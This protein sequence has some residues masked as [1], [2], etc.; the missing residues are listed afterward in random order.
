MVSAALTALALVLCVEGPALELPWACATDERCTQ[1]HNGGSHTGT[2]AWA[3]DFALQHGEEIWAASAGTVTHLRKNSTVSG[4]NSAY[5]ADANFVTI[6]HGD[7]TAII[8]AHMQ[9]G[10]IPLEVGDVVEVGDLIGKVGD[11][12]Y[13]CGSHLH[14]AVQDQ[15]GSSHCQSVPAA[16]AEIGDAADSTT[17][18]S[19]NCPVC[20]HALDGGITTLDDRDAGC[21]TRITTSWWSSMEGH[22]AHHFYTFATDEDAPVSSAIWHVRVQTPGD[23][24][25][26]AF[27][28]EQDAD[29]ENAIY[30]VHHDGGT[31]EVAVDQ[32]QAKGWQALGTFAFSAAEGLAIEL[33]DATGENIDTLTRR[34]GYDA[35]RF[36]FVPSA[37][38]DETGASTGGSDVG[39]TDGGGP[40]PDASSG[41]GDVDTGAGPGGG[42]T[43]GGAGGLPA[44]FG[45]RAGDVGCSCRTSSAPPWLLTIVVLCLRRRAR[46]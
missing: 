45:G 27:V 46:S 28:P 30:L 20:P 8:Y 39:T 33:G 7:G 21:L 43:T 22:D 10:S 1:A 5:A 15:C 13:A 9:T 25:V 38:D 44:G 6:D 11:T 40:E 3:W 18:E 37:G 42:A 29:T 19:S 36:T 17:Y 34:I 23:Y 35:M 41:D 12:G 16:F 2:S 26:E 14:M 24:L 32:A 31:T 4:C